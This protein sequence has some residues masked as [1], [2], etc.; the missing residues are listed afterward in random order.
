MALALS[1]PIVFGESA[2]GVLGEHTIM[3]EHTNKIAHE[4]T[5]TLP[6]ACMTAVS[7]TW[8]C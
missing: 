5:I 1:A 7:L 2:G 3:G 6:G 8:T 4:K